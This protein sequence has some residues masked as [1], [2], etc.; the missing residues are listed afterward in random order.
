IRV[1]EIPRPVWRQTG[2]GAGTLEAPETAPGP[3]PQTQS[4]RQSCNSSAP[5]CVL[6]FRRLRFPAFVVPR[7]T[8][9]ALTRRTRGSGHGIPLGCRTNALDHAGRP[10]L[11]AAGTAGRREPAG[12]S[13][14]LSR[15]LTNR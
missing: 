9:D 5:G 10:D 8:Q 4:G 15:T 14:P 1:A 11:R 12:A 13:R 6:S 3:T 2:D 7:P